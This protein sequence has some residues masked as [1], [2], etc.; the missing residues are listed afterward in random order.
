VKKFYIAIVA[1]LLATVGMS[2]MAS[3]IGPATILALQGVQAPGAAN[4]GCAFFE[5]TGASGAWYALSVADNSFNS[6]FGIVLSAFYSATPVIFA[7]AGSACGFPKVQWIVI[8][9]PN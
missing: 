3:A 2:R 7:T 8:G 6:Q 4:A 5:V 9:T 1:A